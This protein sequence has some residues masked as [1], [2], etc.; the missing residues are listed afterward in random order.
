MSQPRTDL[1]GRWLPRDLVVEIDAE[2]VCARR[3]MAVDAA[4]LRALEELL[5]MARRV[6]RELGRVPTLIDI[7]ATA[8]TPADRERRRALMR[9]L[10]GAADR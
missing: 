3:R 9:A 5:D 1:A 7:V 4:R 8:P 10:R 6:E 2:L